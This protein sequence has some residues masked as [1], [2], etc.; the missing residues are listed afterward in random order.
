MELHTKVLKEKRWHR[1]NFI[2]FW[3]W[4]CKLLFLALTHIRGLFAEFKFLSKRLSICRF[5]DSG[6]AFL[7]VCVIHLNLEGCTITKD[8]SYFNTSVS[9][10]QGKQYRSIMTEHFAQCFWKQKLQSEIDAGSEPVSYPSLDEG[11]NQM[12]AGW[13]AWFES[14]WRS[15]K[16]VHNLSVTPVTPLGGVNLYSVPEGETPDAPN[17]DLYPDQLRN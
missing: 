7:C 12:P 9:G 8:W 10:V 2:R 11:S 4:F 15:F 13:S 14:V 3:M 6:C 16:P 1:W 5:L 17:Q